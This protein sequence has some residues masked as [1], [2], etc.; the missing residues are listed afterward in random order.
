VRDY[1]EHATLRASPLQLRCIPWRPF[2]LR[3]INALAKRI[4]DRA[5]VHE[6]LERLSTE[7]R[8]QRL[9]S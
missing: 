7:H 8:L 2:E 6:L 4:L 1:S 3:P 9:P 5:H